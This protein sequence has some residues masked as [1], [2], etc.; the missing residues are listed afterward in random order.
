LK[1][2]IFVEILLNSFFSWFLIKKLNSFFKNAICEKGKKCKN[3]VF[4]LKMS[5]IW[6]K[7]WTSWGCSI[8]ELTDQVLN[9][10]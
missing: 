10:F 7:K 8:F 2:F 3:K 6:M 5:D 4:E 9:G 1:F